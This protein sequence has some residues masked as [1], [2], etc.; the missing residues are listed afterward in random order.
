LA[1]GTQCAL[2]R[3]VLP[4]SIATVVMTGNL[5]NTV[6]SELISAGFLRRHYFRLFQQYRTKADI[7]RSATMTDRG[8]IDPP[9]T[10]PGSASVVV[11]CVA[12]LLATCLICASDVQ[13]KGMLL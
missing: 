5:A 7:G 4:G 6:P 1:P 10:S 11:D 12:F 13:S 3:L 9:E 8:A 2:L